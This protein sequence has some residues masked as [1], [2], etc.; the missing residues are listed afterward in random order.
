MPRYAHDRVRRWLREERADTTDFQTRLP[1]FFHVGHPR[2]QRAWQ[3]Q[4]SGSHCFPLAIQNACLYLNAPVPPLPELIEASGCQAGGATSEE[5]ALT[6]S[7]LRWWRAQPREVMRSAGII[8]IWPPGGER[9]A[10]F[11]FREG[12]TLYLI[13]SLLS[14]DPIIAMQPADVP[15]QKINRLWPGMVGFVLKGVARTRGTNPTTTRV[16]GAEP[17]AGRPGRYGASGPSATAQ[18]SGLGYAGAGVPA[19]VGSVAS[20]VRLRS[21]SPTLRTGFRGSR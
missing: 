3:T 2:R 11:V 16:A 6:A 1:D 8:L 15:T 5:R 9:H 20:S 10:T 7:G 12:R 14:D 13:N 21:H 19:G 17:D 4:T 18:H